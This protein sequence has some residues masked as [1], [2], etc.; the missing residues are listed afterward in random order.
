MH[1]NQP[2][3]QRQAQKMR[4]QKKNQQKMKVNKKNFYTTGLQTAKDQG[5]MSPELSGARE[6][7]HRQSCGTEYIL[8]C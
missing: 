8:Y 7:W 6:N 4:T 2:S 3:T 5:N 1:R